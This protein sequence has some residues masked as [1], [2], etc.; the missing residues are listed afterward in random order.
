[1]NT[2]DSE[3]V[4]QRLTA[5]RQEMHREGID[6][7]IFPSSDPHNSEYLAPHWQSRRWISGFTG[8]AGTAVITQDEAA[9][10]T[11]S[12]YFLQAAEQLRPE[13]GVWQLMKEGVEGTPEVTDWLLRKLSILPSKGSGASGGIVAID[14]MVENYD[15]V[16]ALERRLR[17]I[18]ATIRTNLD[19][20]T[21]IWNDRP[22]IP[23]SEIRSIDGGETTEQKLS[24]IRSVMKGSRCD[25]LVVSDL[26][27]VAW[28]LNLR[29]S[30][31]K[32]TPVFVAY[33]VVRTDNATLYCNGPL[34]T[35]AQSGLRQAGVEVRPYAEFL[36]VKGNKRGITALAK[37][38]CRIMADSK[39]L[40]Y[41]LYSVIKEHA[42]DTPSPIEAMKSVKNA[43]EIAGFH[44]AMQR[45]G[46]AMVRFLRWLK[47]AVA[48]GGQTE[49]SV[50]DR[51]EA[52]RREAREC[53]D[54]SF[55]T[56]AGYNGHGAI[57]HYSATPESNATLRPEGLLLLDSGGQYTDG[58][59]DIT[60]TIPLGTLTD[61][62]RR[63]YTLVLKANIALATTPFPEGVTG[64]NIDSIARSVLWRGYM[65]Y[66]H[67]TGHG[68]GWCLSVHEGPQSVRLGW[69]EAPMRE[70]MTIT[71]E[72]GVYL[73]GRF[74]VRIENT[75]LVVK[76]RETE[77]GTF[78][79]LE[80]LT[81]CPIDL[82]PVEWDIMTREEREWLNHYHSRVREELLPLLD[83]EADR[84]WLIAATEAIR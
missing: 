24:R 20:L 77:F 64:T 44:R 15:S 18:G 7:C 42:V 33:L 46:V 40:N 10:W 23:G 72:P 31:I 19:L 13:E 26:M 75:M 83:D 61:E 78:L 11:D 22:A 1:M 29:G 30:D 70:G 25:A 80:P 4:L 37:D 65:N 62:M 17:R 3:T 81:L 21:N 74:G 69:R 5:L 49:V 6:A 63:A 32:H 59:T 8:S 79:R 27:Q 47:P 82:T 51:L 36:P 45:D 84:Q 71:D 35:A 54:L 53:Y 76:D 38:A 57:V 55:D 14:G 68:V 66:L 58:T 12:R 43:T 52:L 67:G 73:Q 2:T 60:R 16:V 39:T 48:A 34:T 50:S 9:L 56:I 28:A 41:T